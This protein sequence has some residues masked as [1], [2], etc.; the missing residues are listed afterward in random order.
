MEIL[1][2]S[3]P[4]CKILI[5]DNKKYV[6]RYPRKIFP[7]GVFTSTPVNNVPV[8]DKAIPA[9]IIP[10]FE[11]FNLINTAINIIAIPAKIR[12]SLPKTLYTSG[13]MYLSYSPDIAYP[14][15]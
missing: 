8:T 6:I 10:Q 5:R 1:N 2:T 3:S 15:K 13:S 9:K 12:I 4:Q 7:N 14:I 11:I